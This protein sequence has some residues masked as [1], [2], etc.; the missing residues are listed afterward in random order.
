MTALLLCAC[1]RA[2]VEHGFEIRNA[3]LRPAR[4]D[5]RV[6]LQLNI[7]LSHAARRALWRGVTLE[8]LVNSELRQADS[9]DLVTAARDHW[10]LRYLPLSEQFQLTGPG[11]DDVQTFPRLRHALRATGKLDYRLPTGELRAGDYQFRVRARLDR[12]ALPAPIQLPALLFRRWHHD[13][14][15]T[16]WPLKTSG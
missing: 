9:R 7:E 15:W 10:T 12:S 5:L 8:I 11:Q 14:G 2:P 1:E 6:D 13:S 16:Q 3:T 4:D